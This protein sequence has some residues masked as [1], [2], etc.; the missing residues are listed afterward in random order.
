MV[1][2]GGEMVLVSWGGAGELVG[3]VLGDAGELGGGG[4]V[5]VGFSRPTPWVCSV[6][7]RQHGAGGPS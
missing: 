7:R 5:L 3:K 2:R 1:S 4:V 6:R